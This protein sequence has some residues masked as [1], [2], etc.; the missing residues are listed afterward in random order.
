MSYGKKERSV[1]A[2]KGWQTRRK[3]LPDYGINEQAIRPSRDGSIVDL[4]AELP[5]SSLF[6]AGGMASWADPIFEI[7]Q[8][9]YRLIHNCFPVIESV[10][11]RGTRIAKLNW[12]VSGKGARAD[13]I[14]EIVAQSKN[15][16]AMI[17]WLNWGDVDGVR[18]MQIKTAPA[19]AGGEPWVVPNFFMGGR[20]KFKAGGTIQWDGRKIVETFESTGQTSRAPRKLPL[21]Q[22]II[23]RP[24][25]GSSPE[26]DTSVAIALYRI[27][28][29]WEEALKN[30]DAHMELYG[31]P[32]RVF[33]GKM[34]KVRPTQIAGLLEDRANRLKLLKNNKQMVL[35]DQEMLELIEPKGQGFKDMI[36]YAKYLEGLI[37]QMFL[38]NQLTST[39]NDA[40]RTGNTA[41]HL[42]EESESIYC[43]A[44]EIAEALNRH[45]LPWIVRKNPNLPDL[46]E[47]EFEP[48]LWPEPPEEDDETDDQSIRV[49]DDGLGDVEEGEE[50]P[51]PL[52]ASDATSKA[53]HLD[54]GEPEAAQEARSATLLAGST[55]HTHTVTLD[56][57][58]NGTSSTNDSEAGGSHNH[59]VLESVVATAGTD[60]HTHEIGEAEPEPEP[61]LEDETKLGDELIVEGNP[62]RVVLRDGKY[63]VIKVSDGSVAGTHDTE[64]EARAQ[65]R[66]LEAA[67][68]EKAAH[69]EEDKE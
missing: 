48:Q 45:L 68:A 44:M 55:D 14:A 19:R 42:S 9:G 8:D 58:G 33:K 50:V 26:G 54:E 52:A 32:I 51:E 24:G 6:E 17:K 30:T 63:L 40:S 66:A 41:V 4:A 2:R 21:W 22:F 1:A 39:V 38:A 15:W 12:T 61:E 25:G 13:A 18:Y 3:V 69:R 23:H 37:D 64:E 47:G 59:L 60:D 53:G 56:E 57:D 35:E 11:K 28:F 36:E 10:E 7:D 31:I 27:A 62:W 65:Q 20:K 46:E 67:E 29:S 49:E 34:D 16:A 43:G 5:V